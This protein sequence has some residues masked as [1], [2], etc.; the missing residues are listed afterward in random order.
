MTLLN[1]LLAISIE[2]HFDIKGS[3]KIQ[4]FDF[5]LYGLVLYDNQIYQMK[6]ILSGFTKGS[7]KIQ[8]FKFK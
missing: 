5:K 4:M 2:V 7:L 8:M 3:M 6:D 1:A